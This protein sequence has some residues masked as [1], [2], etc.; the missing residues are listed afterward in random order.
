MGRQWRLDSAARR[1]PE[2]ETLFPSRRISPALTYPP[3]CP[4]RPPPG[5]Q[6]RRS[7]PRRLDGAQRGEGGGGVVGGET[8]GGGGGGDRHRARGSARLGWRAGGVGAT[9]AGTQQCT[10]FP[11]PLPSLLF[12]TDVRHSVAVAAISS[13][14]T[15]PQPPHTSITSRPFPAPTGA[16]SARVA[17]SCR[18]AARLLAAT[19]SHARAGTPTRALAHWRGCVWGR[20]VGAEREQRLQATRHPWS[21]RR[22]LGGLSNGEA[23]SVA[24]GRRLY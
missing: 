4:P 16:N 1:A 18:R 22:S 21:K 10:R 3:P 24:P 2:V 8:S 23:F 12:P 19:P 17:V 6:P 14:R 13:S 5:S 20:S 9:A 11:P 15:L 7:I